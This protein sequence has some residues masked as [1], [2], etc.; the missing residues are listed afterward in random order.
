M[1]VVVRC[2]VGWVGGVG[3]VVE[4]WCVLIIGIFFDCCYDF[5]GDVCVNVGMC[6]G[7]YFGR[8]CDSFLGVM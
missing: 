2:D 6:F 5:G 8:Y 1:I 7:L 3:F 4:L